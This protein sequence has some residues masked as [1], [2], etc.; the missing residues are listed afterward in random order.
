MLQNILGL[1]IFQLEMQFIF[2]KSRENLLTY[3]QCFQF[4]VELENGT[5]IIFHSHFLPNLFSRTK[6]IANIFNCSYLSSST[7]FFNHLK[8]KSF[9]KLRIRS[10]TLEFGVTKN[11]GCVLCVMVTDFWGRALQRSAM[12]TESHICSPGPKVSKSTQKRTKKI[13]KLK[14]VLKKGMKLKKLL[15]KVMG[16][17]IYSDLTYQCAGNLGTTAFFA[18]FS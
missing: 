14:K 10:K 4:K 13:T 16:R 8:S 9:S 1:S 7:S 17:E 12:G 15:K 6:F 18:L 11:L 2:S 3:P 5:L